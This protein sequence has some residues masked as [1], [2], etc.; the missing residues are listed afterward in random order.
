MARNFAIEEIDQQLLADSIYRVNCV[1]LFI[2]CDSPEVIERGPFTRVDDR[3]A[4]ALVQ[5]TN[6]LQ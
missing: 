1:A 2:R 6:R 3:G 4:N 5:C